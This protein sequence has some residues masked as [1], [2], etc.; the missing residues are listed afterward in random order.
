MFPGD[1]NDTDDAADLPEGGLTRFIPPVEDPD[2]DDGD[3]TQ[4]DE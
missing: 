3:E 2:E 1:E 4:T